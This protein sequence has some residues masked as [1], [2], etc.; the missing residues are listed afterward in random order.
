VADSVANLI[1]Q[2]SSA[3]FTIATILSVLVA[4]YA[5]L[6][7]GLRPA[8]GAQ[9]RLRDSGAVRGPRGAPGG[10]RDHPDRRP[11]LAVVAMIALTVVPRIRDACGPACQPADRHSVPGLGH[12]HLPALAGDPR[13]HR[14]WRELMDAGA[15]VVARS[16]CGDAMDPRLEPGR[17][18]VRAV[19]IHPGCRSAALRLCCRG[20]A[21]G[22]TRA[23][24]ACCTVAEI[25]AE[26][27]QRRRS[28]LT[29]ERS[30]AA[31]DQGGDEGAAG[32]PEPG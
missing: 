32:G 30:G 28:A 6:P 27:Q 12:R 13:D 26:R 23:S 19:L 10:D 8:I 29:G 3:T 4:I 5:R 16:H 31:G 21:C 15:L 17:G 20:S 7:D 2:S 25:E 14:P 11:V 24:W 1:V 22:R 9:C 18:P